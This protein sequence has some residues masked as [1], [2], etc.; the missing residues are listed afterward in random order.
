MAHCICDR[1][2]TT[3]W[4]HSIDEAM[5]VASNGYNGRHQRDD[6]AS[7]ELWRQ[8]A[9]TASSILIDPQSRCMH[10]VQ[11]SDGPSMLV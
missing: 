1:E 5:L 6:G 4:S 2:W 8:A 7:I 9:C 11:G 3:P 10:L